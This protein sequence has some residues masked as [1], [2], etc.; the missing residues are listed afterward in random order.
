VRRVIGSLKAYQEGD[1]R[2]DATVVCLDWQGAG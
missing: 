1:R 2:D